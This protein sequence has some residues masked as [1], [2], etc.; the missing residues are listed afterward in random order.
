[1]DKLPLPSFNCKKMEKRQEF[2]KYTRKQW[3]ELF[4]DADWEENKEDNSLDAPDKV[5]AVLRLYTNLM[6]LNA[7]SELQ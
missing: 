4:E 5:V 7:L 3:L 6:T 2:L 1:M